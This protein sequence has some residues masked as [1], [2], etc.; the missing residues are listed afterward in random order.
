M[1]KLALKSTLF[2]LP[3]VFIA[4]PVLLLLSA[5]QQR[6]LVTQSSSIQH[7]DVGRIKAMLKQHDPRN[8]QDGEVRALTVTQRDLNLM[9]DAALPRLGPHQMELSL[10]DGTA[11]FRYTV[12]LPDNPVGKYLNLAVQ[13]S[14]N[15][16]RLQVHEIQWGVLSLPAW[17]IQP[18]LAIIDR[19]L[20][21][22]I[23]EYRSA[24]SA[25]QQV[26]LR[27]GQ[28]GLVYQWRASLAQDIQSRGRDLFLPQADRERIIAYYAEIS[29]QS[30][31]LSGSHSLVELLQP[32][33]SLAMR[34]SEERGNPQAE[35]RALFLALGVLIRGSSLWRLLGG[36]G[37]AFPLRPAGRTSLTLAQRGDLTQ[38]FALSAA[39]TAAAGV[40]L[41]DAAGIFK[42]IDDSRGGTGFSFPDLL[43]DRAGVVL[44]ET[45][46]GDRASEIQH[47]MSTSAH[48][49]D[50][51]PDISH[52]PEGLQELE[53]KHRYGD[54][55]SASYALVS[56]EIER[57]IASCALYH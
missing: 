8:L 56:A 12:L 14:Q 5:I 53:F 25:V 10:R 19:Y 11:D 48:E 13:V 38:H 16:D 50:F 4:V 27:E 1:L 23:E 28:V 17:A 46:M 2:L 26:Q 6:P 15:G 39:I 33:F 32:L 40:G 31:Q 43:A 35:N 3:I 7:E 30:H 21:N 57:R 44:A 45:A 51:M 36:D 52:L 54:L 24:L 18:A 41:A 34:R 47:L 22:R 29:R 37:Y 20:E 42:E 9:L 55:D 49:S